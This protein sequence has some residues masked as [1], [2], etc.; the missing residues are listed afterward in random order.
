MCKVDLGCIDVECG[1]GPDEVLV[2]SHPPAR[3]R[4]SRESCIMQ[5]AHVKEALPELDS[6]L[7]RDFQIFGN[8]SDLVVTFQPHPSAFGYASFT[9]ASSPFPL[10]AM[11]VQ[12]VP[13]KTVLESL[14][15][16]VIGR[17][18]GLYEI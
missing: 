5:E 7:D 4:G 14:A 12:K 10:K 2:A 9:L 13:N 18:F 11:R 1:E 16:Q 15:K 8:N 3:I 6:W 17:S